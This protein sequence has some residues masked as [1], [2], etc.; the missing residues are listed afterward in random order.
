MVLVRGSVVAVPLVGSVPFHPPDA[1]QLCASLA[2]HCK[3]VEV[4]IGTLVFVAVRVTAGFTLEPAQAILVVWLV[5]ELPHA[6]SVDIAA[7]AISHRDTLD[8]LRERSVR[9]SPTRRVA[10]PASKNNSDQRLGL[11]PTNLIMLTPWR[12][13]RT[14]TAA[15]QRSATVIFLM[16]AW[17]CRFLRTPTCLHSRTVSAISGIAE[18]VDLC[19][20]WNGARKMPQ[21]VD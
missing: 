13:A 17:S 21:T 20:R 18:H 4:P 8:A 3:T 5:A 15:H 2:L 1:E 9:R 6:A 16:G 19:L 11:Q 7:D 10:H 12:S 14:M